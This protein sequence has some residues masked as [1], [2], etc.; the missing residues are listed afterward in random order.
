VRRLAPRPI[1]SVL[2]AVVDQLAP[3][4]LLARVQQA[5]PAAAGSAIAAAAHPTA[6]R[7]GVVTVSCEAAVWAQELELME[8]ALLERLNAAL[9]EPAIH[10]L[11]CRTE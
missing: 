5:W 8:C 9:R 6:E 7:E 11:R 3:A 1:S 2:P 4:T 10:S